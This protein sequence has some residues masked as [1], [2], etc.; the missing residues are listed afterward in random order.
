MEDRSVDETRSA[1]AAPGAAG[2]GGAPDIPDVEPAAAD[3]TRVGAPWHQTG[4]RAGGPGG[5]G[6]SAEERVRHAAG[7]RLDE[8]ADAVRR[9]GRNAYER[10][11]VARRVDPVAQRLG[12]G[13]ESAAGYV[14][15]HDVDAMR[16]DVESEVR[17]NPVRSL[18]VAAGVGFLLGRLIR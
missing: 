1:G 8:A 15:S 12:S 2:A 14:R 4:T 10:G 3:H 18:L 13:L 9:L 6:A 17:E 16:I 11:G 7:G 5:D